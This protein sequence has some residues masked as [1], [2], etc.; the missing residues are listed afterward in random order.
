MPGGASLILSYT[1]D[2]VVLSLCEE[3][4]NQSGFDIQEGSI[5]ISVTCLLNETHP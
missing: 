1:P 4:E 2:P 5:E 3:W